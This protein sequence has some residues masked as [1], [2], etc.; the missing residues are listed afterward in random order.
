MTAFNT[1]YRIDDRPADEIQK[2]G[3]CCMNVDWRKDDRSF[4]RTLIRSLVTRSPV[5]GSDRLPAYA[6]QV[7]A[8]PGNGKVATLLDL[9]QSIKKTLK[10]PEGFWVSTDLTPDGGGRPGAHTYRISSAAPLFHYDAKATAGRIAL[11][12]RAGAALV[13]CSLVLDRPS[14]DEAGVI[15]VARGQT[16][17]VEVAFLTSLTADRGFTI[18]LQPRARTA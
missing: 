15:G 10:G 2:S 4:A 1:V 18:E 13:D 6:R 14:L 17:L 7:M 8:E 16:G 5:P 12:E 11:T 3:F 9:M